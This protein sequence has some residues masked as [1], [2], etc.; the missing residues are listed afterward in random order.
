MSK[1]KKYTGK[2]GTGSLADALKSA[3]SLSAFTFDGPYE[4]SRL[5]LLDN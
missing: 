2:R 4:A 5:D 3:P 1:C